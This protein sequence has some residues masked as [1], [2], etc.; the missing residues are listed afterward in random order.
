MTVISLSKYKYYNGT[1]NLNKLEEEMT[2]AV[3][4]LYK[5]GSRSKE[6]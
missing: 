5:F 4:F 2:I 1:K 6:N 3:M